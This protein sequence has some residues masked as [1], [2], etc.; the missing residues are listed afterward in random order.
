MKPNFTERFGGFQLDSMIWDYN[1]V[2]SQPDEKAA[3]FG[4]ANFLTESGD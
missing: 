3:H 1:D 4:A 2:I